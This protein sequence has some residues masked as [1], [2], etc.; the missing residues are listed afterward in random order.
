[1]KAVMNSFMIA[2][3]MYS[4]IPMPRTEW[5][6]ENMKY[7]ICFFPVV[8]VVCGALLYA[9]SIICMSC[10]FGQVCFALVGAVLPVL[11]TGGIHVDGFMDTADALH[12]YAERE[13]KLEILKDPHIGA[14][15]VIA[16]VCYFLLCVAGLTQVSQAEQVELLAVSFVL[17]RTLS[18]LSLVWFPAAKKD[19]LLYSFASTA[20]RRIVR[21]VLGVLF[22]L[23]VLL[24]AWIQP[25][26]GSL[27]ALAA[28]GVW[29]Y[30]YAMSKRQFGGITG[31]LAGYF[32]CLCELVCVLV[33]G[34][35]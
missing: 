17:S 14:F 29:V 21:V 12:S 32:L 13:K 23:C 5:K 8:G 26:T 20:H 25:V 30:Y 18:G 34:L 2:M 7:S 9:W 35:L 24:A 1:M 33:V 6:Q 31:D 16:L 3:A 28:V 22:A 19:G 15:S 27:M 4:K 11:V 10:G